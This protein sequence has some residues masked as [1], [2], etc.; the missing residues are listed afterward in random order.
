[1]SFTFTAIDFE[2]AN[3]A[4]A[5]ACSVGYT[6]VQDSQIIATQHSLIY[7]PTG[8]EFTNSGLHGIYPEDVDDAPAFSDVMVQMVAA[9]PGAPLVAYSPFDKGVWNS[10]WNMQDVEAPSVRFLDALAAA[11]AHLTLDSYRLPKVVEHLGLP[12]FAHHNAGA[13]ALACAQVVLALLRRADSSSL[14]ELWPQPAPRNGRPEWRKIAIPQTNLAA[15][16][17]HPLHGQVLCF[18]GGLSS[19]SRE[20]AYAKSASCG[21]VIGQNVTLKTTL[22]IQADYVAG[23]SH[24]ALTTKAKRALELQGKGHPITVIGESDFLALL[25]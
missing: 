6:V 11:R 18:T 13:D 2:T 3:N 4:R 16:P 14:D 15:N 12:S 7:P 5:S 10:A 1:M 8:L 21:A 22:V 23:Q 9:N 17:Q 24:S 25:S 20:D 19:M